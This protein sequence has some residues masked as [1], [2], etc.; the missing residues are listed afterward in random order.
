LREFSAVLTGWSAFLMCP[1]VLT[2][3]KEIDNKLLDRTQFVVDLKHSGDKAPT[4]QEIK[5]MLATKMKAKP[6]CIVVFGLQTGFGGGRTTGFGLVYKS[7]DALKAIE[8]KHRLIKANLAEKGKL[9]RRQ[10]KNAR[11]QKMKVWGSGKRAQKHKVR[12]QQ[13]KE[14]AEGA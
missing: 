6:E 12:R 3:R 14:A 7:L 9:T 8:P 1:G 13:R 5:E 4:R 10:R 11:K 2:I